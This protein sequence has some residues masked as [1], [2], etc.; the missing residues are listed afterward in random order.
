M[1]FKAVLMSVTALA[2]A[3][4]GV[5]LLVISQALDKQILATA[6][7]QEI[8]INHHTAQ[9]SQWSALQEFSMKQH[10][11]FHEFLFDRMAPLDDTDD[12]SSI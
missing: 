9:G 4:L 6:Q 1:W 2:V 8:L 5:Q 11:E 3:L 7:V 10:A 12:D